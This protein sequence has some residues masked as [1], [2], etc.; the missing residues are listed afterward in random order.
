VENLH[1]KRVSN[2]FNDMERAH[3]KSVTDQSDK[4]TLKAPD[5]LFLTPSGQGQ[6]HLTN[7]EGSAF[8]STPYNETKTLSFHSGPQNHQ[9]ALQIQR[10]HKGLMTFVDIVGPSEYK[11]PTAEMIPKDTPTEW[12]VFQIGPGWGGGPLLVKDGQDVPSRQW[13]SYVDETDGATR[14]GLWDGMRVE[15]AAEEMC[16]L[17]LQVSLPNQFH[18]RTL[19]LFLRIFD[20]LERK[21]VG[22]QQAVP[23]RIEDIVFN[24]RNKLHKK[25]REMIVTIKTYK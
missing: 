17:N 6:F 21:L 22:E 25:E 13:I 10:G 9:L 8:W 24:Q 15:I 1:E 7:S 16:L 5:N 12:S 4:S 19:L 11:G 3:S 2:L 20:L 14:V 23:T 18:S